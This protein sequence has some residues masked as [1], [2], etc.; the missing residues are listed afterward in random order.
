[1]TCWGPPI[2]KTHNQLTS[3]N[4][5]VVIWIPSSNKWPAISSISAHSFLT[6]SPQHR[7][8]VVH[9]R[10]LL[11]SSLQMTITIKSDYFGYLWFL[12]SEHKEACR[13]LPPEDYLLLRT[14][15]TPIM[16]ILT[17]RKTICQHFAT[18]AYIYALNHLM[19]HLIIFLPRLQR[20]R[21]R[22]SCNKRYHLT[23]DLL[24]S[25]SWSFTQYNGLVKVEILVKAKPFLGHLM[26]VH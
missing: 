4:N 19:Y 16:W 12:R 21:D 20:Y 18:H 2:C 14:C 15:F 26:P 24:W 22:L 11:A 6:E 8:W 17:T 25:C 1:M 13:Q 7:I 3:A 10:H 9:N 23:I 5:I